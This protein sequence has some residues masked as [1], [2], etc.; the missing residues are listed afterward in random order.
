MPQ[1]II[2]MYLSI[3]N[4]LLF[5]YIL[6]YIILKLYILP[7]IRAKLFIKSYLFPPIKLICYRS[8]SYPV[9]PIFI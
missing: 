1:T 5:I 2:G 9:Y 8:P 6:Y 4:W 7:I 3:I